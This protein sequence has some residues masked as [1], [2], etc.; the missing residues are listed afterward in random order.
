L[1]LDFAA[2]TAILLA[3]EEWFDVVDENDAVVGREKRS[4]VH[5]RNLL[6][7]A[8]HVLAFNQRGQ[9]FLQMRS[10]NKDQCP[11][12]WGSSAAGHLDCGET[13]AQAARREFRE[14]LG[15][16]APPLTELFR[17]PPSASTGWEHVVVYGCRCDGP[18][19]LN[20]EEIDRGEWLDP[21]SLTVAVRSQD[22]AFT[23]SLGTVWNAFLAQSPSVP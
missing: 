7:R 1:A 4:V 11:C 21:E 14:E 13:Y 9:V 3:M 20:A 12:L 22:P 8:V 16:E 18:F 10:R 15:I 19:H 5:A 17:L 23:P 6:H 2:G